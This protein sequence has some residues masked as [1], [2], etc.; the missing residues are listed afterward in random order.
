MVRLGLKL[1][2]YTDCIWNL[3]SACF[4]LWIA[5][6]NMNRKY[7]KIILFRQCTSRYT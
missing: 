1:G 5:C 7:E 3:S 2:K 6:P 4:M